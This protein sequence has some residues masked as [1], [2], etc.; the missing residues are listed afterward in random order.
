MLWVLGGWLGFIVG[1][2]GL[3]GVW[4]DDER[5]GNGMGYGKGVWETLLVRERIGN[6]MKTHMDGWMASVHEVLDENL[7]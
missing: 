4:R 2:R 5:G 6:V 1:R 3:R 7:G